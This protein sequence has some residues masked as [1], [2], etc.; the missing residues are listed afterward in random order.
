VNWQQVGS[1]LIVEPTVI[2]QGPMIR[3]RVTPELSGMVDGQPLHTRFAGA[4]TEIVVKDG[5]SFSI[6]GMAGDATFYSRFLVGRSD[7]GSQEQVDIVLTPHIMDL[8]G[9]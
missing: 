3:V 9:P 7:A 6:G 8:K 1:R 5:E 2:G 4:T